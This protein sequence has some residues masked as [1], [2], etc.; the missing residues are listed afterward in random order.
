MSRRDTVTSYIH[1]ITF[2]YGIVDSAK[3]VIDS[4][5]FKG[6]FRFLNVP[7]GTYYIAVKNFN[8][9]E[10]W[11]KTG[12][13]PLLITDTT[14]YDFTTAANKAYGN[15]LILKGG[16]YCIYSGN[17]NGDAIVDASDLSDVDNDSYSALSGRFLRSD[18]NADGTVDAADVSQV[19]NNRSVVINRPFF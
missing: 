16:K 12:G 10:T 7:T 2:P 5:S 11:S 4:I 14:N 17:V 3:S 13:E 18:V 15:N 8:T 6:L 19:D 1:N 9:M